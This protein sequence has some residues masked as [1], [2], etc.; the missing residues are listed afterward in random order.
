MSGRNFSR[1]LR[2]NKST[3][4][5]DTPDVSAEQMASIKIKE[6]V[7]TTM[8]NISADDI[9]SFSLDKNQDANNLQSELI[10]PHREF[11]LSKETIE[12]KANYELMET[13]IT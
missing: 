13:E 1:Q 2:S 7:D 11:N 4:E 5:E 9:P 6:Q 12:F 8:K 10:T 3:A